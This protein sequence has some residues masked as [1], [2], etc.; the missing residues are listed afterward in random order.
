MELEELK[1][2]SINTEAVLGSKKI[3]CI[4]EGLLLAIETNEVVSI[5]HNNKY[6]TID[7]EKIINNLIDQWKK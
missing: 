2:L 3:N 4:K 1:I 5:K 7:S 6:V